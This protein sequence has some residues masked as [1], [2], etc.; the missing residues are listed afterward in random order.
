MQYYSLKKNVLT[1]PLIWD[2]YAWPHLIPPLNA[3]CNFKKRYLPIM[4]SFIAAPELHEEALQN[5]KMLGGPFINLSKNQVNDVEQLQQKILQEGAE[6]L[7]LAQDYEAFNNKLQEFEGFSFNELYQ[8]IPDSLKGLIELVY[9]ENHS[10]RIR[11]I[12]SILYKKFNL[13]KHQSIEF[14]VTNNDARDFVMATPR[15]SHPEKWRWKVPFKSKKLEKILATESHP[16]SKEEILKITNNFNSQPEN[17][18]IFF[19]PTTN[20]QQNEKL[21][22]NLR[23]RYFGHACLLLETSD[24]AILIDP[25]ISPQ[26]KSKQPRWTYNDL[27]ENIDY[28]L[29]THN[30]TDHLVIETLL[31][32]KHKVRHIVIPQSQK[33]F[34]IDPSMKYILQ[35][36]G[37]NNIIQMDDFDKIALPHGQ[38]ISLP[39]LGEHADLDIQSKT[40]YY[41]SLH[42]KNFIFCA[43]SDNLSPKLYDYIFETLP[44]I[45][46][47]FL[48]MECKG[49]P[50]SWLYGPLFTQAIPRN[51]DISRRLSGSNSE[52]GLDL[53]NRGKAK[54][55]C[56]YAMGMEPWLGHIMALAY[57][58]DSLQIKEADKFTADCAQAGIKVDKPYLKHE[59]IF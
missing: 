50:L 56:L 42:N 16:L 3:G 51:K 20:A 31:R 22:N 23:M 9:D 36:L 54:H 55:V 40:A 13:D 14:S 41:I 39:F 1:E 33:G 46:V 30:H 52:R 53:V 4:E 28:V 32:I 43:D 8:E 2:W 45:D 15:V 6:I 18:D 47:I 11:F 59:W 24:I 49:A 17:F 21:S 7:E 10:P 34:I 26:T 35:E 19:E 25:I 57:T 37:F 5:P 12:E 29:I 58:H 44:E 27:P 48:G 38:I